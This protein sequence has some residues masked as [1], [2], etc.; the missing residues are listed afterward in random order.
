MAGSIDYLIL[1]KTYLQPSLAYN[2]SERAIYCLLKQSIEENSQIIHNL[3]LNR[4]QM[5]HR[6][7]HQE[8]KNTNRGDL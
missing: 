4:G 1:Q 6:K 3:G 2:L 5:S 7:Q 8:R